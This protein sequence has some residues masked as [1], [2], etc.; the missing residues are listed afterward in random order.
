MTTALR[1]NQ[2]GKKYHI[3]DVNQ[4]RYA[5]LRDVVE[6]ALAQPIHRFSQVLRGQ[7]ESAR[8]LEQILWAL[9][10]VSFE[11]QQ[12]EVVGIVGANGA[13]K[14]TLLKILSQITAPTEG[15]VDLF[16]RTGVLLEVGTGFHYELTGRENIYLNGAILGMR[17]AEIDR[18]F[19]EIVDFSGIEAFIDT[20][21]KYYSSGMGLRLGFAVAAHL[22][23][24]ILLV[25]EVLAV[26]D[27][28]FQRKSIGKLNDI[29]QAG[30]TVLFVSHN[31]I[32]VQ[33]LCQRAIYL[34]NGQLKADGAVAP[35]IAQYL[36]MGGDKL[37]EK[38]WDEI[39]FAPGSDWVRLHRVALHPQTDESRIYT[40][41]PLHL[42]IEYWNLK[43]NVALDVVVEFEN[44]QGITIFFTSTYQ[45][46]QWSPNFFAQGLVRSVCEI[47]G[48]LFNDGLYNLTITFKGQLA[49]AHWIEK[50][51]YFEVHDSAQ[52]RGGWVGSWPGVVR[53]ILN[54]TTTFQHSLPEHSELP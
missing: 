33:Q 29:A 7:F 3:A 20:P 49:R 12:G 44:E 5:T 1:V 47:P 54:W 53:P 9:R 18:K 14:S 27:A 31:L 10:E 35:V 45:R 22:E 40:H 37:T 46:E 25:D 42:E 17:K 24:A 11:V 16:G 19:D 50:I 39:E 30:R 15:Q 48:N 52:Y 41:T 2:L 21:I 32:A 36:N 13:G 34:D 8:G 28:A 4:P 23:P 38:T 43:D 26:G 6:R 51:L